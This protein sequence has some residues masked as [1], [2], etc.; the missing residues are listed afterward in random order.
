MGKYIY[1]KLFTV[2]L[3]ITSKC[4]KLPKCSNRG[5]R[6]HR[7]EH[8]QAEYNAAIKKEWGRFLQASIGRLCKILSSRGKKQRVNKTYI[9]FCIKKEVKHRKFCLFGGKDTKKEYTRKQEN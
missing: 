5:E 3:S 4:W 1:T 7:E 2:A 9:T 6:L 8:K